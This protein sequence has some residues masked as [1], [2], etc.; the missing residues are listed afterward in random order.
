[1]TRV[2][3][4]EVDPGRV[5]RCEPEWA[6]NERLD[7]GSVGVQPFGVDTSDRHLAW[8]QSLRGVRPEPVGHGEEKLEV[9]IRVAVD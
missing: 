4:R 2:E 1:M 6:P 7:H 8:G 5:P 3:V 9:Q